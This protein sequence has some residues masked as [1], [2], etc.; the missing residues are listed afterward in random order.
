VGSTGITAPTYAQNFF[1]LGP[2]AYAMSSLYLY[3]PMDNTGTAHARDYSGNGRDGT[4]S[5][6]ILGENP[7]I[8]PAGR[9][10]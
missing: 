3:W 4:I 9:R 1:S 5:G 2:L 10:G 8:R 6:A 7:P